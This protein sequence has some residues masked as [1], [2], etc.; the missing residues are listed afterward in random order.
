MEEW[1]QQLG[2]TS[3]A[4]LERLRTLPT[5]ALSMNLRIDLS[6]YKDRAEK[7]KRREQDEARREE[8]TTPSVVAVDPLDTIKIAYRNLTPGQRQQFAAWLAHGAD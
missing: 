8:V 7:A 2:E 3:A 4:W 5:E 6:H 1:K